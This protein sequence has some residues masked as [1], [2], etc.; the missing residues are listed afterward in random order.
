MVVIKSLKSQ[1]RRACS[2]VH[3]LRSS[4]K[5]ITCQTA[6]QT[7]E[8]KVPSFGT[9]RGLTRLPW[10]QSGTSDLAMWDRREAINTVDKAGV[11]SV[12][13]LT[14]KLIEKKKTLTINE[15]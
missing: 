1:S 11:A 14:G 12:V 3:N 6:T 13:P 5:M 4:N 9:A 15:Q 2:F 8:E 7:G 10:K